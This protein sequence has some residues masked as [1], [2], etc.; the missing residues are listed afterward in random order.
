MSPASTAAALSLGRRVVRVLTAARSPEE[1]ARG[2]LREVAEP[3]GWCSGVLWLLDPRT[4]LLRCEGDWASDDG[5]AELR[6]V[7]RRL[8]FAPGVGV[9]G[10]VFAEVT[11]RWMTDLDRARLAG[12]DAELPRGPAMLAAGVRSVIAVP[13]VSGEGPLGVMEFF[14][15]TPE[16]EARERT[17]AIAVV[18]QQLAEYL[19]RVRI[20]E[21]L[22]L[23][24]ASSAS[25][26]NAA[27]DC[28]ITMDHRGR[29]VDLNPAAE[30]VFGYRRDDVIG[31]RL[32]DLI[33]PPDL[34]DAHQRS[35]RA[36][37]ETGE[38]SILNRRL[39][40]EGMRADGSRFPVELTVTRLGVSEPPVFAG[41]I[42]DITERREA[43]EQ[44]TRLLE[45]LQQTLLPPHLPS[46]P[47][48]ELGAAYR[49]GS[50]GVQVGGDFF[51]VFEL[52]AGR[53]ALVLG[54]VSGK[55]VEAAV[56][57]AS[58]RHATRAAGV[59]HRAPRD[60]VSAL[61]DAMLRDTERGAFCTAI[62]ATLDLEGDHVRVCLASAG[63]PLPL[64]VGDGEVR[65]VG[66]PGT[67]LG[68]FPA[69]AAHQDEVALLPGQLLVLYTDGVTEARTPAGLFGFDRLAAVLSDRRGTGAP[70]IAARIERAVIEA[71]EGQVT[72][73]L[74]VLAVRALS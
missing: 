53:W 32:A 30:S 40:L 70:E 26:V 55:G 59:R 25:I 49:A 45:T 10:E 8:T 23:T 72:D 7:M 36:Y 41:F 15:T 2:V 68:A 60:V 13:V 11:P 39:E 6:R 14:T 37:V 58:L 19:T 3:F 65:P 20:E 64:L 16:P 52:E 17:D 57:T 73:D 71:T 29:V 9:P 66:R 35:L 61:N 4:G 74:A 5:L 46:V 12:D 34:R 47:R 43:D 28:I 51:D 69:T 38:A 33:I 21:R 56:Q 42:R 67:L 50:E 1:A 18:G 63:H 27:L 62:Y 31:E 44:R 54:D 22:R 24:E 48:L